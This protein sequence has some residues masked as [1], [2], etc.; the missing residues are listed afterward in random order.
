MGV[1][2]RVP[3]RYSFRMAGMR[4]LQPRLIVVFVPLGGGECKGLTNDDNTLAVAGGRRAC[5]H[6]GILFLT[7]PLSRY[8]PRALRAS[9]PHVLLVL[10][11]VIG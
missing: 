7:T 9:S 11:R 6:R 1:V 8:S 10:R 2:V 4:P 5:A 3:L